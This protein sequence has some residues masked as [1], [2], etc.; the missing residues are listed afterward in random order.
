MK[1]AAFPL[2][3]IAALAAAPAASAAQLYWDGATN[4]LWGTAA[5]WADAAASGADPAAA[6]TAGDTANFNVTSLNTAIVVNLG[7]TQEVT[8][9]NVTSTGGVTLQG[10]GAANTL[11]IGAGG[12]TVTGT[13]T[14]SN[15]FTVGNATAGEEVN[16]SLTASQTWAYNGG[17]SGSGIVVRNGVSLANA[18]TQT[19][20]LGGTTGPNPNNLIA[21]VISDGAGVLNITMSGNRWNLSGNN[22]YTGVT[23]I[24]NGGLGILHNNALGATGAGSGTVVASGASLFLRAAVTVAENLQI[25]GR[26]ASN[27]GALRS[28]ANTG[29]SNWTGSITAVTSS[30]TA[31]AIGADEGT[32]LN[33]SGAITTSGAGNLEFTSNGTNASTTDVTGDISG[34]AGLLKAGTSVHTLVLRGTAKSYTG[35]TTINAGSVTLNTTL[36]NTASVTVG[37]SG[38]LQGI[39]GVIRAAAPVTVNGTINPGTSTTQV[40]TLTMGNLSLNTGSTVG[41]DYSSATG[42]IDVLNVG[43]LNL[44][45]TV[46]LSLTDITSGTLTVGQALMFIKTTGVWNGVG[47]TVDGVVINDE[48]E[49]FVRGN[50]TFMIDYNRTIGADTGVA[51]VVTAV[52][53]PSAAVLALLAAG[54]AFG[55]RRRPSRGDA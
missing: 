33:I 4:G 45:G 40:S 27:L 14:N 35:A 26:G 3:A 51:L 55:V 31:A 37:A 28:V 9:I 46:N 18:G 52:P 41:I 21:G 48:A 54:S 42:A 1:A 30:G 6:P 12:I 43:A 36:S 50:H 32:T 44:A 19:L 29:I 38:R 23:T 16:V 15:N 39:N 17:S 13:G 53:E 22:T 5:N 11:R 25:T 49:T 8:G 7:A 2:F 24:S 34:S 10:G 20:T 47:F